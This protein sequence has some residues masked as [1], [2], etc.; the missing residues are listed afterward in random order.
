MASALERGHLAGVPLPGALAARMARFF[1]HDLASVRLHVS[2]APRVLGAR[3]FT[4]G[5]DVF[6]DPDHHAPD[7]V[8]WRQL[9]AHELAHVLQQRLGRVPATL[10]VSGWSLVDDPVLEEEADRLGWRAALGLDWAHPMPSAA[11][12]SGF[13]PRVLQCALARTPT[14]TSLRTLIQLSG[15]DPDEEVQGTIGR[16]SEPVD[17]RSPE[18]RV[19]YEETEDVPPRHVARL[20]ITRGP[21][22]G[23]STSHYLQE[24]VYETNYSFDT[25]AYDRDRKAGALENIRN[26]LMPYT[27]GTGGARTNR[28]YYVMTGEIAD[29]NRFAEQEHCND[30][31]Y[32]CERTLA[33]I[34]AA[35]HRVQGRRCGPADDQ[36]AARAL[37]QA[38]LLAEVPDARRGLGIEMPAW[39]HE[40]ERLRGL[41]ALRDTRGYHT[42][43]LELIA[44]S[45]VPD[46]PTR[47]LTLAARNTDGHDRV[48]FRLTAGQTEI[49]E[50]GS[51]EIIV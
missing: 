46:V 24:G 15:G 27:L 8:V 17:A 33:V 30:H 5:D 25:A 32:A 39:L 21:S 48:Y 50:H 42:W 40:Y 36:A 6:I 19:D 9:I 35:L 47:Y 11:V 41:T 29:L 14:A 43:G 2:R 34:H 26:Y 3:A 51:P 1:G 45:A 38:A 44:S 37:V 13:A 22:E 31:L 18:Y 49:N 12:P 28:V 20:T 4:A 7:T 23:N 16:T 10:G